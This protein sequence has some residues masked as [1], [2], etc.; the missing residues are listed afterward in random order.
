MK[1]SF[2]AA[3]TGFRRL[4]P[5]MLI[6]RGPELAPRLADP[7]IRQLIEERFAQICN[8][9]PYDYDLHGY[10]I[11]VEPGDSVSAIEEES[12][13]PILRDLWDETHF[14]EPDYV[15]AAEAIE[16]HA[17]CYELTYVLSD[18]GFGIG[19]VIPKDVGVDQELL[20]MCAIYA[21]PAPELTSS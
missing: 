20:R 21:V 16:E 13:C 12:G 14:G 19:I 11:V 9:E 1:K 3:A 6:L 4:R 5:A 7:G 18:S 8:G 2:V 10:I 15:P 17:G